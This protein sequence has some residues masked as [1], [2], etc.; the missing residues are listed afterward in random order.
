[1]AHGCLNISVF[2]AHVRNIKLHITQGW[3]S[4]LKHR[5]KA[6]KEHPTVEPMQPAPPP[7][8]LAHAVKYCLQKALLHEAFCKITQLR[9]LSSLLFI[10]KRYKE[11]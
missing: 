4:N 6:A 2:L 11:V 9:I 1:M 5:A 7:P 3:A 10:K 8:I